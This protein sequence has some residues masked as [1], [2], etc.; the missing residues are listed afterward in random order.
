[1]CV[2]VCVCVCVPKKE[3]LAMVFFFVSVENIEIL[4]MGLHGDECNLFGTCKVEKFAVTPC[5]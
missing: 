2:C 5:T 4:G 3:V 1:M